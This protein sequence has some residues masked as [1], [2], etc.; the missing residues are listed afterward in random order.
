MM[1]EQD[2][3]I[4]SSDDY[5]EYLK[6]LCRLSSQ[7]VSKIRVQFAEKAYE[8]YQNETVRRIVYAYGEE[9]EKLDSDRL[10]EFIFAAKHGAISPESMDDS[11]SNHARHYAETIKMLFDIC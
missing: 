6:A 10:R 11:C 1:K 5:N 7:Y 9:I 2:Y 4:I 8:M 3:K